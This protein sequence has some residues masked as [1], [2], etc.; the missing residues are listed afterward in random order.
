M[1]RD[2]RVFVV[3]PLGL[4]DMFVLRGLLAKLAETKTV[5]FA[6]KAAY[7]AHAARVL[8][9]LV[10]I[11]PVDGG[12]DPEPAD[13]LAALRAYKE[14]FAVRGYALLPLGGNFADFSLAWHGLHECWAHRLY[15]QCGLD[16]DLRYSA[17]GT[18]PGLA[19]AA[20]ASKALAARVRELAGGKPYVLVHDDAARP[21]DVARLPA[22]IVR[23]TCSSTRTRSPARRRFTA[24]TAPSCTSSTTSTFPCGRCATRTRAAPWYRSSGARRSWTKRSRPAPHAGHDVQAQAD[25]GVVRDV[26]EL[27]D[28]AV[29][30]FECK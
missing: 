15:L 21:L 16:P 29:V 3:A 26:R 22:D 30:L 12:G 6:V 2:A 8:G 10:Q 11:V 1:P 7:A 23:V 27:H 9:D 18:P 25:V 5:A 24:S 17:F 13:L 4:G 28:V 19:A 20:D 14:A